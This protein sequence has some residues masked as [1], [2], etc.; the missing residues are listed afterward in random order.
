MAGPLVQEAAQRVAAAAGPLQR[1]KAC[2]CAR[3]TRRWGDCAIA[4]ACEAEGACHWASRRC[5]RATGRK[6]LFFRSELAWKVKMRVLGALQ[7]AKDALGVTRR[8]VRRAA[9]RG[10]PAGAAGRQLDDDLVALGRVMS[11]ER[12]L[13]KAIKVLGEMPVPADP[14]V[15]RWHWDDAAQAWVDDGCA[16]AWARTDTG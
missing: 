1:V 2:Q 3:C 15:H 10:W 11:D 7:S 9:G 16:P 8:E 5:L 6:C 4:E 14:L 13:L 12:D